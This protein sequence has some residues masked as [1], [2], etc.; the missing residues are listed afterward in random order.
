MFE[1]DVHSTSLIL[2]KEVN[3]DRRLEICDIL[4]RHYRH[5]V[6]GVQVIH[7]VEESSVRSENYRVAYT[8]MRRGSDPYLLVR[9]NILNTPDELRAGTL[10]ME[11]LRGQDILV[12]ELMPTCDGDTFVQHNGSYWQVFAFQSGDHFA[13]ADAQLVEVVKTIARMHVV[14]RGFPMKDVV[15]R[16][17]DIIGPLDAGYWDRI[18]DLRGENGFERM[19]RTRKRSIIDGVLAVADALKA[20]SQAEEVNHGDIHPHNILIPW[21]GG[22]PVII[23]FGNLFLADQ[24][25]DLAMGLHRL[26]RQ[27]IVHQ[28]KPWQEGLDRGIGLFLETQMG[29]EPLCESCIRALPLFGEALL[30][31]KMAHNF[32]LYMEG[33][34]DWQGCLAQF[35]RFFVFLNE[36]REIAKVMA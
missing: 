20:I 26:V 9:R 23:D 8:P 13:G 17:D 2:W 36:V 14:L 12:P 31:R 15:P 29:V 22:L 25:H 4:K 6:A 30:F 7:Q 35:Q 18:H 11:Y 24:R 28:R 33:K 21:D 3:V 27:C 19:L 16:I 5:I 34:R 1:P 32:G 10:V